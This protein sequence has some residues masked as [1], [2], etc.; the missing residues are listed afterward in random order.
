MKRRERENKILAATV[1]ENSFSETITDR[2]LK[3]SCDYKNSQPILI[4]DSEETT[5]N[6]QNSDDLTPNDT[7]TTLHYPGKS[8]ELY[9]PLDINSSV[10]LTTMMTSTLG[11]EDLLS[12]CESENSCANQMNEFEI[13]DNMAL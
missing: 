5:I 8:S 3:K 11:Q 9:H 12:D 1:Y 13:F 6:Q 4:R 2:I 7:E 10:Q